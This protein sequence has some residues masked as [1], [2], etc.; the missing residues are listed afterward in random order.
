[1]PPPNPVAGGVASGAKQTNKSL[2]CGNRKGLRQPQGAKNILSDKIF[3]DKAVSSRYDYDY[4]V[5]PQ[6][7][8]PYVADLGSMGRN[9]GTWSIRSKRKFY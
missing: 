5:A 9:T 8:R 4:I 2:R 3:K 7:G 6:R 1:M